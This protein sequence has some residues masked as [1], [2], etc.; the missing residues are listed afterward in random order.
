MSDE[1]TEQ[2]SP[3]R[4]NELRESGQ[5]VRSTDVSTALFLTCGL[6][7]ILSLGPP[8]GSALSDTMRIFFVEV[9]K[10]PRIQDIASVVPIIFQEKLARPMTVF[11]ASLFLVAILSQVLQFGF[12]LAFSKKIEQNMGRLN[13]INGIKQLFSVRRLVMSFQSLIKLLVIGVFAWLAIRDMLGSPI[14]HRPLHPMEIGGSLLSIASAIGWKILMALGVIAILDFLY[15]KWQFDHDNRM[16]K[17]ELKDEFRQQEGA[18]EVKSRLRSRRREMARRGF[19]SM[20]RMLEDVQ[21]ATIVITNPTHY[22]VALRYVRGETP[23]PIVLAKGMRRVAMKIKDQALSLH[24]PMME[25]K[26][27]A[28]G[29]YKHG[30][31]DEPIPVIFYQGVAS[32]L[33]EMYKRGM[34]DVRPKNDGDET[35]ETDQP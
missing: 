9:G 22:A 6:V 19:K 3:K 20:S 5:V 26:P 30:V 8:I 1:K 23:V 25:N 28:Q 13:P 17:D 2:A 10:V 21:D 7:G 29:L 18:F 15:Q 33:A 4:Q 31:M 16:S 34:V 27:L 12:V 32:L 14:F 24:V 11:F 35:G